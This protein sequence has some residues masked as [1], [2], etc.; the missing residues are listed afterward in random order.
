[1]MNHI[2]PLLQKWLTAVGLLVWLNGWCLAQPIPP[3]PA[4]FVFDDGNFF[5]AVQLSAL[6]AEL[7]KFSEQT[8]ASVYVFATTLANKDKAFEHAIA[9]ARAWLGKRPGL[10]I[11][12]ARNRQIQTIGA[13]PEFWQRYGAGDAAVLIAAT[14]QKL[15]DPSQQPDEQVLAA[16]HDAVATIS[17]WEKTQRASAHVITQ[18]DAKIAVVFGA[19]LGALGILAWLLLRWRGRVQAGQAVTF[20]FPDVPVSPRLGAPFGGGAIA[21]V[22]GK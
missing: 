2:A 17:E 1:M 7:K 19:L 6:E 4:N 8:E 11:T 10:V 12:Y 3:T 16:T 14:A 9:L 15:N 5:T 18:V 20:V 13:T 22:R 21:E